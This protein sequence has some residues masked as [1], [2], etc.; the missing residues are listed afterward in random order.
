M[1]MTTPMW[2]VKTRLALY[3]E[4]AE[5]QSARGGSVIINVV[6][7]MLVNEGPTSFF[8]GI[9]PAIALS[10]YGIV[11]MYCYENIN[12]MMGYKTGQ[13]MTVENFMIPFV[14]GGLSKSIASISLMPLN[15]I[16]LRL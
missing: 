5:G 3:K 14:T 9:G 4:T 15:V 8:K 13:K 12:H 11:Q 7:D 1:I 10:S 6:R 16:R 2:V